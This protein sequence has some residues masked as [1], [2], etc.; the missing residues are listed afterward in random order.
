MT[1]LS[2]VCQVR[3]INRRCAGNNVGRFGA[4]QNIQYGELLTVLFSGHK[5]TA[6]C[7]APFLSCLYI[8][9]VILW[10]V[11]I[12]LAW[13]FFFFHFNCLSVCHADSFLFLV[14]ST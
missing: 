10:P 14:F 6:A 7:L 5:V 12:C 11:H 1:V 13:Q 3:T 9:R 8:L 2:H 4:H